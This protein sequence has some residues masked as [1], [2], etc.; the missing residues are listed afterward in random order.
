MHRYGSFADGRLSR[1]HFTG[2]LKNAR[3]FNAE[4]A[5]QWIAILHR[6]PIDEHIVTV[7]AQPGLPP[8]ELP[9]L[10]ESWSP[11]RTHATRCHLAPHG[12]ENAWMH[13]LYADGDRHRPSCP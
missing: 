13:S 12:G 7:R 9:D 2:R 11:H 1:M 3:H 8:Q 5:Q 4:I 10:I 6:V